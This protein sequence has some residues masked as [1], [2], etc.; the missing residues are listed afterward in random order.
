MSRTVWLNA[1]SFG[2]VE[3]SGQ[4]LAVACLVTQLL[5]CIPGHVV[6]VT[7]STAVLVETVVVLVLVAGTHLGLG[8]TCCEKIAV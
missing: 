5:L 7:K 3:D 4:E 8:L 6:G 2:V 1:V